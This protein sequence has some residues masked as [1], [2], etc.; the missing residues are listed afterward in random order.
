M[1]ITTDIPKELHGKLEGDKRQY[2]LSKSF[3]VRTILQQHYAS[4]QPLF[5]GGKMKVAP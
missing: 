2:G 5:V 4:K 3:I 1:I